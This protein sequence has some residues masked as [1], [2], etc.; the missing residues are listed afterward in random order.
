MIKRKTIHEN[1]IISGISRSQF[2]A[3]G[4]SK[5]RLL[6]LIMLLLLLPE[7][8]DACWISPRPTPRPSPQMS[9]PCVCS[10][11]VLLSASKYDVTRIKVGSRCRRLVL[12]SRHLLSGLKVRSQ[13]WV[14]GNER[15]IFLPL[16]YLFRKSQDPAG[17]PTDEHIC[18]TRK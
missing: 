8:K 1:T 16:V 6:S 18:R 9:F 14:H 17:S 4:V 13:R 7:G 15:D 5:P 11:A 2:C 12:F 3:A 10:H